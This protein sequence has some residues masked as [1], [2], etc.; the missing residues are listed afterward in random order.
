M[1]NTK[2]VGAVAQQKGIRVDLQW[3]F[4]HYYQQLCEEQ[5]E[6][7]TRSSTANNAALLYFVSYLFL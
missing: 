6:Q 1:S 7:Q 3:E 2:I 4:P 5:Y